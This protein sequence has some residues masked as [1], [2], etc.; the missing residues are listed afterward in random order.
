M[1]AESLGSSN[2]KPG[3]NVE[4]TAEREPLDGDADGNGENSKTTDSANTHL[5]QR[6]DHCG[7]QNTTLPH[8]NHS[9]APNLGPLKHGN[10]RKRKFLDGLRLSFGAQQGRLDTS[11]GRDNELYILRV[12]RALI[13]YGAPTHRLEAYMH[14]SA[15]ALQLNIKA[16]YL[17]GCMLMSFDDTSGRSQDVQIVQGTQSLNLAKLDDVHVIYK[18]VIHKRIN[19]QEA[20]ARLDDLVKGDDRFP[21]WSR[22]L[23]YGLASAFIGPISYHA[24]PVDLP[25]IFLFG[26]VVG[27]CELVIA[28]GSELYGYVFEMSSAILVSFLAR[29]FGSIQWGGEDGFCFSAI[30][31]ASLVMILPGFTITTSALELQSKYIVTGASRLIYGIIYTMFLAFGFVVGITIFGAIDNAATS[32]TMCKNVWPFWW[33]IAFV[34]PFISCYAVVYQTK[35]IHL[36]AMLTIALAGWVVNHFSALRFPTVQPLSQALGA[37]TVGVLANLYSRWFEGLAVAVMHPAIFIQVPGSFA[38]S[39]SLINGLRSADAITHNV[40]DSNLQQ[41]AVSPVLHAGYA[42]VEIAVGIAAGLSISAL[43]TYPIRKKRGSG[44]LFT[45]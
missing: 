17:P 24:R 20:T 8:G 39:G 5:D 3:S 18:D 45:Y 16:F 2:E 30:A 42:M 11:Q 1:S 25:L 15:D 36:P 7:D 43:L 12:C 21:R 32:S 29:A 10:H 13:I 14:K 31:Q 4:P 19:S 41:Q 35:W 44:G 33:Q 23:M 6:L 38:A 22:V 27:F 40:N 28:A 26:C 34:L 37:V 9:V